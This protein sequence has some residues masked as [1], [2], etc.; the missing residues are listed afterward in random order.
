MNDIFNRK[1]LIEHTVEVNILYKGQRENRDQCDREIEVKYN[2]RNVM[3]Y[4]PQ[5]WDLLEDGRDKDD[6]IS[7]RVW[8]AVEIKAGKI[9]IVEIK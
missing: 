8:K 3:T 4:S 9:R 7:G 5:S 1:G 6:K 2:P